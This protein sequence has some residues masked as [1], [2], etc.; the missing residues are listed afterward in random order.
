[1]AEPDVVDYVVVHEL[2]HIVEHNHSPK[3]W[4]MVENQI[5]DYRERRKKLKPLQQKLAAEVWEIPK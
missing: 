1:M 5:P 3:F 4:R 2:C